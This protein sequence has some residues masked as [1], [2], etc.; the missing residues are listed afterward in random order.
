MITHTIFHSVFMYDYKMTTLSKVEHQPKK[1]EKAIVIQLQKHAQVEMEG[2][3]QCVETSG[4][5]SIILLG[6]H[7]K[8]N[9]SQCVN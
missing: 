9:E 4:K 1:T 2:M 3:L 6:N 8:P 7:D 5:V